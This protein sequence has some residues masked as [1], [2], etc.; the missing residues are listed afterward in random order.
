MRAAGKSLGAWFGGQ[1]KVSGLI[2]PSSR[3]EHASA[4]GLRGPSMG[5]ALG[6]VFQKTQQPSGHQAGGKAFVTLHT[7]LH[8]RQSWWGADLQAA[9]QLRHVLRKF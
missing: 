6:I 4:L 8:L 5:H 2:G 3:V 9:M 7:A 1:A